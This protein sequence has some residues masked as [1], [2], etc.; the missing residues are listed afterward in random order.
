MDDVTE[1][2]LVRDVMSAPVIYIYP[3]YTVREAAAIMVE[4]GVGSLVVID[5]MGRLIG[6]LTRTDIMRHVVSKGLNPE[7]VTV[8]EVMTK[9][10]IYV[11]A[12][13]PLSEAARLMGSKGIGH[14]PVLDSKTYKPIGM[15]SKRDILKMAPYYI[16][17]VYRLRREVSESS[18]GL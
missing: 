4:K 5:D 1:Q 13:T 17:L 10:P 12:D 16:D 2:L 18:T 14:L 6:I 15:L 3:F 7:K 11:L 9:N 8:G